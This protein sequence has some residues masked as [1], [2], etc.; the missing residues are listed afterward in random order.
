M[1]KDALESLEGSN[2]GEFEHKLL[3]SWCKAMT[4]AAESH[5]S[6]EDHHL[7]GPGKDL[8]LTMGH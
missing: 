3:G 4:P 2:A 1:D 6:F 5:L 8:C 7:V